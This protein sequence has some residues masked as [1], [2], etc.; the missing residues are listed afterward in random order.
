MNRFDTP[1]DHGP[2]RLRLGAA[3]G[4]LGVLFAAGR[5]WFASSYDQTH[6]LH[7]LAWADAHPVLVFLV[8]LCEMLGFSLIAFSCI[9]LT[10]LV[11][12]RGKWLTQ[13]GGWGTT[14][15]FLVIA[16]SGS[17]ALMASMASLPDRSAAVRAIT[18]F[19]HSGQVAMLLVPMVSS[20]LWPLLF[21]LGLPRAGLVGWWYA[22]LVLV[23]TALEA[24][25]SGTGLLALVGNIIPLALVVAVWVKLLLDRVQVVTGASVAD[26]LSPV[27]TSALDAIPTGDRAGTATSG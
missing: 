11:R 7:A 13:I 8:D 1:I 10:G 14:I 26:D 23:W 3:A 19:E 25:V 15:S 12:G 4:V 9:T 17:G 18:H 24:V 5:V 16:F 2:V 27:G 21:G 20:V 6:V 22:G